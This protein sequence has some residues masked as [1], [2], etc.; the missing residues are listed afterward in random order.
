MTSTVPRSNGL[1]ETAPRFRCS[2]L[3]WR[4][5]LPLV[6]EE[7][8]PSVEHQER[9]AALPADG[10]A[11][12]ALADTP[13]RLEQLEVDGRQDRLPDPLL[14]GHEHRAGASIHF[15][16]LER[17]REAAFDRSGDVR[18]DEE[19]LESHAQLPASAEDL[20]LLRR[21][22]GQGASRPDVIPFPCVVPGHLADLHDSGWVSGWRRR[23]VRRAARRWTGG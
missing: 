14:A 3:A 5:P 12:L 23:P 22:P 16:G 19:A 2:R 21:V 1:T 11:R 4:N 15:L 6:A 18:G 13:Q 20:R 9:P 7:T 17:H 10:G 8:P